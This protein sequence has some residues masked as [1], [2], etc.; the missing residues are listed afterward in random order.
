VVEYGGKVMLRGRFTISRLGKAL[1]ILWNTLVI[2][3]G[4]AFVNAIL[5]SN[6]PMDEKQIFVI[7]FF[8]VL[9]LAQV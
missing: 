7:A 1:F 2:L 3:I 9:I 6:I 4:G 5:L 8:G